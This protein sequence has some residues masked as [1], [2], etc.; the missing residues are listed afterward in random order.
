MKKYYFTEKNDSFLLKAVYFDDVLNNSY[1]AKKD[2]FIT[3]IIEQ[4]EAYIYIEKN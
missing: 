3:E 1:I 4:K 2:G